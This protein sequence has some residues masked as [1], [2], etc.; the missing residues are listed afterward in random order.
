MEFELHFTGSIPTSLSS[1]QG[2]D[3]RNYKRS[4]LQLICCG[5]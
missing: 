2:A 5:P 4:L 3:W 1:Q